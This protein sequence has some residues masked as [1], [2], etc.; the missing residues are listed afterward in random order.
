[1]GPWSWDPRCFHT[2]PEPRL[3]RFP[4]QMQ[5]RW[6]MARGAR[7][8]R[9]QPRRPALPPTARD[10]PGGLG[11]AGEPAVL[12]ACLPLAVASA[13]ASPH[14]ENPAWLHFAHSSGRP[15]GPWKI[16]SPPVPLNLPPATFFHLRKATDANARF[17]LVLATALWL[18]DYS[19]LPGFPP[20]GTAFLNHPVYTSFAIIPGHKLLSPQPV[21]MPSKL[22]SHLDGVLC[23]F[24][25]CIGV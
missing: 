19:S 22:S 25:L 23:I 18:A 16:W 7:G 21:F 5:P 9:K 10:P 2:E 20:A 8:P 14:L 24:S 6:S 3:T 15:S 4:R 13:R 17:T 1:M 11:C 12:S